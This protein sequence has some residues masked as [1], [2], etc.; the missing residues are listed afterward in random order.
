MAPRYLASMPSPISHYGRGKKRIIGATR[1]LRVSDS[2]RE[3]TSQSVFGSRRKNPRAGFATARSL[4]D[5]IDATSKHSP[6][7]VR[8]MSRARDEIR[9]TRIN[10]ACNRP[11]RSPLGNELATMRE[12]N[13]KHQELFERPAGSPQRAPP[14]ITARQGRSLRH[15]IDCRIADESSAPSSRAGI[16]PIRRRTSLPSRPDGVRQSST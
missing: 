1:L 15:P 10:A 11:R 8:S 9:Y 13:K 6:K 4:G 14:C 5:L 12:E 16:A 3:S 2:R 7:R